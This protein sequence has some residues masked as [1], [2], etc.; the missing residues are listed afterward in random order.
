MQFENDVFSGLSDEIV[1]YSDIAEYKEKCAVSSVMLA[2]RA[3]W[4]PSIFRKEGLLTKEEEI[5]DFLDKAR[6]YLIF[7]F[8]IYELKNM[9]FSNR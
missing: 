1:K 2:R 5:S 7:F 6:F 4:T 3:L 8:L 9:H